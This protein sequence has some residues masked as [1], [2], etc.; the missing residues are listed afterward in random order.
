MRRGTTPTI[1]MN[2]AGDDLDEYNIYV[3]LKQDALKI[4]KKTWQITR[5]AGDDP[6]TCILSIPF[7]QEETL[8]LKAGREASIQLRVIAPDGIVKESGIISLGLVDEVLQEGV[9]SYV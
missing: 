6:D 1:I 4:I 7:T 9:L 5:E 8:S 2:V 3:T